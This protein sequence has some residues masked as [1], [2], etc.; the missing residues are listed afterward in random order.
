MS[1]QVELSFS[2]LLTLQKPN[3]LYD[4]LYPGILDVKLP[5]GLIR[6]LA[7]SLDPEPDKRF[8]FSELLEVLRSNE[9]LAIARLKLD[10]NAG[11]RF[12]DVAAD[13]RLMMPSS[14][15]DYGGSS[16]AAGE[17]SSIASY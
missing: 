1:L 8:Q 2:E 6:C 3:K 10:M 16:S 17:S 12:D 5:T 11:I 4:D 7:S 14:R 9:G 15:Y 13:I